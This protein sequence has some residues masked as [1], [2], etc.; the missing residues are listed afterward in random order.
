MFFL[1]N[2]NKIDQE[3]FEIIQQEKQRKIINEI[4]NE[5]LVADTDQGKQL[6]K[7][8]FRQLLDESVKQTTSLQNFADDLPANLELMVES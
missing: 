2:E 3:L 8:V 7:N 4:F 6:P 5:Y 1:D